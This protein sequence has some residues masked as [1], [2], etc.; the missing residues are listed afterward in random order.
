[1]SE[2]HK[3]HQEHTHHN[4]EHQVKDAEHIKQRL[5][6]EASKET[7]EV[8]VDQLAHQAEK[9]AKKASEAAPVSQES[10]PDDSHYVSHTLRKDTLNRTLTQ[11]RKQLSLPGRAF[12]KVIHQPAIDAISQASSKTI[13]RPSGLLGGSIVAF[14]GSSAFLWVARHYGFRY[15]Y[16]LFVLFFAGGFVLGMILELLLFA[17]RR[18]KA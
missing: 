8:D 7:K 10:Q 5:E 15:N 16:L 14:I 12:S 13:A 9:E 17:F 4:P 2:Q 3:G 6:H 18:K 1:M 11:V